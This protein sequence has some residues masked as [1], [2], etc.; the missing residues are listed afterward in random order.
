MAMKLGWIRCTNCDL[1]F[2]EKDYSFGPNC[3]RCGGLFEKV[4]SLSCRKGHR[5]VEVEEA[6]P[7][8]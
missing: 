5:M 7:N 2:H 6:V 3:P 1:R 4:A 8:G